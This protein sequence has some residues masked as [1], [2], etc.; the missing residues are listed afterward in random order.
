[1][2]SK[3]CLSAAAALVLGLAA[4]AAFAHGD[5]CGD[6]RDFPRTSNL[7]VIGL[8]ADQRLVRFRACNP[9]NLRHIGA[10]Y[11]LQS[12]DTRL[13]GIDFRVD[14]FGDADMAYLPGGT[15][16]STLGA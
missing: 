12:P 6:R 16:S 13:V 11:G 14:G 8:T 5:D 3:S 1:M 7:S 2:K 10:I 9:D 4:P 15:E